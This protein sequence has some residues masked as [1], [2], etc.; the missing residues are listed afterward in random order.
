MFEAQLNQRHTRINYIHWM[1]HDFV[2]LQKREKIGHF[3]EKFHCKVN[4]KL[5][6]SMAIVYIPIRF[7]TLLEKH[8]PLM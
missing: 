3:C 2:D 7:I 1:K 4:P 8:S 5:C 6:S